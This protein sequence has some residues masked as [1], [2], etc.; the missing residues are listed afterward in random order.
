MTFNGILSEIRISF[1]PI[2]FFI[3]KKNENRLFHVMYLNHSCPETL[4][5]DAQK[6]ASCIKVCS[7]TL[8]SKGIYQRA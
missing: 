5:G 4:I 8:P 1:L 3:T 7:R 2:L 6:H